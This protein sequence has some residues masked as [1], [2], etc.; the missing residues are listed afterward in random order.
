[1]SVPPPIF[2]L[3]GNL[4]AERTLEFSDWTAGQTQRA[5]AASFQVGGKGI[6]VA[7]MLHRLGASTT[8]LCFAGGAPGAECA[9][10][11]GQQAFAHQIFATTR[12]TRVGFVVRGGRQ[13]ETTF[14]EPDAAPD[15]GAV[16]SCVDFLDA[17][18]DGQILALCGSAPGWV[19]PEFD[20]LRAA[21]GRWL[22][23]GTLAADSYGPPLAWLVSQRLPLVKIN[24]GELRT[25]FP[26][27]PANRAV[28]DLLVAARSH[29]P[30]Q[31]WIVT[32]GGGPVWFCDA[33]TA[34]SSLQPPPIVEVSATGSG[35]VLFAVVLD[36]FF[37]RGS[38][39]AAAL[40][41]ALPYAAANAAHPGI[42][43]FP[44]FPPS[45][46]LAQRHSQ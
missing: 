14:F 3:T 28:P 32:D 44:E 10:W 25:L 23:R 30:V 22:A 21:L 20:P 15:A 38:T 11:L 36:A 12:A 4:L 46:A 31:R 13:P 27:E 33:D 9:V 16:R 26:Q 29:W 17:Q 8:A 43:E 5:T 6:N 35:D 34:P 39:L 40:K 2:T 19:S 41:R 18:P 7:K 1:M 45:T 42:A 24:A 37:G